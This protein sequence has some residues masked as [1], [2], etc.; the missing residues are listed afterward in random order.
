MNPIPEPF[1]H[2]PQYRVVICT[3]CRIGI[4]PKQAEAHWERKH[5]GTPSEQRRDIARQIHNITSI[6][7]QPSNVRYPRPDE[8]ACSSLHLYTDG[9][10]CTADSNGRQCE[11]VARSIPG[12]QQHCRNTHGWSNVQKRGG[13]AREKSVQTAN[14]L[15]DTDQACQ[16]LFR[17][18]GWQRYFPVHVARPAVTSNSNETAQPSRTEQ[19]QA[20]L[21]QLFAGFEEAKLHQSEQ[22]PRH[23]SEANPWLEHTGW[24]GHIGP[25]Q[26][27]V[28]QM[29]RPVVGSHDAEDGPPRSTGGIETVR[30]DEFEGEDTESEQA[31]EAACK[32]TVLLIRRSFD[33]CRP[34]IVGRSALEYV[35]RREAGA[36]N[37][38]KPFYGK[39]KVQTLQ[40]YTDRWVKIL[41]YLWRTSEKAKE[42]RPDYRLTQGQ[43]NALAHLKA[44]AASVVEEE[45]GSDP[46]RDPSAS[47]RQR[48]QRQKR[49]QQHR[50]VDASMSFWIAMFDHELKDREYESGVL[51]GLA[52]LGLDTVHGGWMP[53]INYTPILA[54]VITTLRAIVVRR[55]WRTRVEAIRASIRRGIPEEAARDQAPSVLDGVQEAVHRFMTLTAFGGKPTPLNRIF[56]QK[57]YGMK[58]RYTTKA[59]GQIGWEGDDSIVVRKIKFK[60]ADIRTVVH[61]LVTTIRQRL[62]GELLLSARVEDPGSNEWRPQGMPRFDLSTVCD[63]HAVLDEG[64]S[65]IQHVQ[66][67]WEVDGPTWMGMRVFDDPVVRRRFV[68]EDEGIDDGEGRA[69]EWNEKAV[70]DYLRQIRRFKEELIVLVHMTA[71]APARATELISIMRENGPSARSQR[72]VFIH[73][74]MVVFVTDYHKGFSASQNFKIVHR[75]VPREVGELVV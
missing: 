64:W 28:V 70:H 50:F 58:I 51:S 47:E 62:I 13:Y 55:A 8:G 52:V 10:R 6:A 54:A 66:N 39:Q 32:A 2:L 5:P 48:R 25:H 38:D 68:I 67:Q 63:D 71:G 45:G 74:G 35:N 29:I 20:Y 44:V 16:Q 60:M 18:A 61:G 43:T 21:K 53:A 12:I 31:L 27:L 36:P 56:Q 15:W 40:K 41:R 19:G 37:N 34:E 42:A 75:S 24:E 1:Q 7:Q 49:R 46:D 69:V 4:I 14:R 11:Y 17:A 73:H 9:F 59:E 57:T 3:S 23:R 65:F 72:G 22:G 30:E 26:R 33:I